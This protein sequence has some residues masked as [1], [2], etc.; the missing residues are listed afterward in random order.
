MT[1]LQMLKRLKDDDVTAYVVTR[2]PIEAWH[3]DAVR[4]LAE[5]KKVSIK[6]LSTLHTKLYCARTAQGDF[7]LMGSANLTQRSLNNREIGL[8]VTASGAGAELVRRLRQEAAEIYRMPE[9]KMY[10]Q[11]EFGRI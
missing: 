8:L 7:A 11:R 9:S 2:P 1:F 3:D 5:T 4:R 10:C 6:F